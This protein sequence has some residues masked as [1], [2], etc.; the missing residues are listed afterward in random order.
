[1][2]GAAQN[3]A[4]PQIVLPDFVIPGK[5]GGWYILIK[6]QPG[7]KKNELCGNMDGMLRIKLK[8]SAVENRANEALLDFLAQLLEIRKN[9][10]LLSSG[11]KNRN[12][13]FFISADFKPNWDA[14][15]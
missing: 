8:A 13:R 2:S 9:G 11:G 4:K 15:L 10:I 5:A 6:V 12:K 1:M 7:A 14:L 3:T